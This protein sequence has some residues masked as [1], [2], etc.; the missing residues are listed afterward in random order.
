MP[1]F[2]EIIEKET[3]LTHTL[4]SIATGGGDIK[5]HLGR[6]FACAC[7]LR[8]RCR[9]KNDFEILIE[10]LKLRDELLEELNRRECHNGKN[11]KGVAAINDMLKELDKIAH[12]L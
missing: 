7:G 2:Y 3:E 4:Y 11:S 9:G 8:E 6:Q 10:Y 5:K 12:F 1:K